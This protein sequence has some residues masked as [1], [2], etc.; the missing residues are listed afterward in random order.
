MVINNG[1]RL[2]CRLK[3]LL[4]EFTMKVTS[5][6]RWSDS[7]RKAVEAILAPAGIR[8]PR[9]T[10]FG[11]RFYNKNHWSAR[12][13]INK[14]IEFIS[15][16]DTLPTESDL[17]YILTKANRITVQDW[18]REIVIAETPDTVSRKVAMMLTGGAYHEGLHDLYSCTRAIALHEIQDKLTSRLSKMPLQEW[19]R[20]ITPILI[21][22]NIIEDIR[23]ERNGIKKYPAIQSKLEV[24]QDFVLGLE[25]KGLQQAQ[26]Q[27]P[28]PE[29]KK[30]L[31]V[32]TCTFR[33]L[34]LGYQTLDGM[35]ALQGYLQ[36][37]PEAFKMV[38]E[39]ELKPLLDKTIGLGE[40][41]DLEHLWIAMDI[42][43]TINGL[44][45]NEEQ[46]GEQQGEQGQ[47]SQQGEQGEQGQD[48]EGGKGQDGQS[49]KHPV[50]K[51]GDEALL[52]GK[53]VRVTWAGLQDENGEQPLEVEDV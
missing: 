51:V 10:S 34:G 48:G 5:G 49:N 25:K 4:Q 38:T 29:G 24:L 11:Q 13:L 44:Y 6:K 27:G 31:H 33:D 32:I 17:V 36:Q 20:F 19:R 21:W 23:I 16:N 18:D 42:V 47:E 26:A 30:A 8:V 15:L 37:D 12:I 52:N 1:H 41:D 40:K 2:V 46:Q 14:V 7:H 35:M 9:V 3:Q 50:Y 22:G 39:G 43:L 28:I 45:E 53:K